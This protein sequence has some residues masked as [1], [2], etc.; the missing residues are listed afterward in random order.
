MIELT[1]PFPPSANHI[2]QRARKG[3]RYTDRY[4]AWITLAT[5][6]ARKQNLI[7]QGMIEGP[8]KLTV[9]AVRPDKR[10]RDLDNFAFKA[11]SDLLVRL[12]VVRDDSDCEMVSA[13]WVT[14]GE[15]VTVRVEPAGVE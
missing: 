14:T 3:M 5:I 13:R 1:L 6:E 12:G 11:V 2:W 15:G 4:V 9:H 10:K 8:Y 7:A